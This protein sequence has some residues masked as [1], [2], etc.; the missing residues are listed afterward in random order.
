MRT[1]MS[2]PMIEIFVV[3]WVQVLGWI[4]LPGHIRAGSFCV[5]WFAN[6]THYVTM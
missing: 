2:V 6:A 3:L 1:Y 5:L 4:A